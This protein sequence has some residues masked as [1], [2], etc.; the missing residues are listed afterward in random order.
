M[1]FTRNDDFYMSPPAIK[2][3]VQQLY[4]GVGIRLYETG[5]IDLTG[6]SRRDV[7]RLREPSEPLHPDLRESVSM[8]TSYVTFDARQ[9]PF[10]D[11][12]VR[13]AFALATDK[14][15][16]I[17]VTQYGLGIPAK[18]L[19][20]PALPGYNPNL[21]GLGFD[22]ALARQ[23]LAQSRYGNA[24]ALPPIVFT[25]Q[26][27]GSDVDPNVAALVDMWHTNLGVS[28]QVENL[29]PDNA[30]DELHAGH[31]GQL[32]IFNWCA[33]Y[34]DPE[35]FA[36]VLFHTGAQQNLGNYSNP[37][38]D[39]LLE[40]ARVERDSQKRIEMYGQAEEMLTNDA[41]AIFL[42]HPLSF[43]LV[44]PYVKGYV[45]TPVHVPLTRYLSLDPTKRK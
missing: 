11:P 38:L 39:A 4:A 22:P 29:E 32:L 12:N 35:N 1:I 34:P 2:Y 14:R 44:K 20:P 30:D 3:I 24:T 21:K 16:Y 9:P 13:Q 40:K 7:A 18:G 10:D 37:A 27:F 36:D 31:H 15:Q 19:Y 45:I 17:D 33:D 25:S 28:I 23:R 42:G 6:V 5:S 43:S 41:A 8:C 26:G